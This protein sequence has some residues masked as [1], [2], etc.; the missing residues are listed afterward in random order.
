M[1]KGQQRLSVLCSRVDIIISNCYKNVCESKGKLRMEHGKIVRNMLL[2]IFEAVCILR[3]SH[4]WHVCFITFI[5]WVSKIEV[6]N[7][8][9]CELNRF[10]RM[11]T[12]T[13]V[14]NRGSGTPRGSSE[15]LQGV[16]QIFV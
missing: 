13:G 3:A 5:S 6:M 12:R 15:L 9:V 10:K 8:Y 7:K 11:D 1:W 4:H 2:V 14:F 16:L